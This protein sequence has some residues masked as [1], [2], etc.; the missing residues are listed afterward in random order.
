MK[1]VTSNATKRS[2]AL[3]G[4]I[5]GSQ[6]ALLAAIPI[7]AQFV[8]TAIT[9]IP[10]NTNCRQ[11]TVYMV[12][13]IRIVDIVG[14]HVYGRKA[15]TSLSAALTSPPPPIFYIFIF[16]PPLPLLRLFVF[17][18]SLFHSRVLQNEEIG[19]IIDFFAN[20][21]DCGLRNGKVTDFLSDY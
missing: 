10:S 12:S 20:K 14:G 8:I 11:N 17:P 15:E 2:T 18:Q 3:I 21:Q 9:P 6:S 1:Y 7:S 16:S 4:V 13:E 5:S 19:T